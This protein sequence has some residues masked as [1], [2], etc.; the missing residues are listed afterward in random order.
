MLLPFLS[1]TQLMR[2]ACCA[3][4]PPALYLYDRR[5]QA[6]E[7]QHDDKLVIQALLGLKHKTTSVLGALAAS[8]LA[9]TS[10]RHTMRRDKMCESCKEGHKQHC[11]KSTWML[12]LLLIWPAEVFAAGL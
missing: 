1:K 3:H 7:V 8:L 11:M 12:L 10:C 2:A 6:V 4:V 9:Q 5:V